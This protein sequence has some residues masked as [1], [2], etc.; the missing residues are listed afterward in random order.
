[1][2]DNNYNIHIDGLRLSPLS[3]IYQSIRQLPGL[4]LTF[5]FAISRGSGENWFYIILALIYGLFIFPTTLLNFY[6]FKYLFTEDELIIHSGILSKK[7]RNIPL[8]RIQNVNI[9]Q[10]FIQRIFKISK[11]QME[12]AGDANAEG[13]LD[14][15]KTSK[16][17]EIK[18]LIKD[19]QSNIEKKIDKKVEIS[20]E[21]NKNLNNNEYK[22]EENI[23]STIPI[24][25]DEDKELISM[26]LKQ[27]IIYGILRFRP[28]LFVLVAWIYS[29]GKQFMPDDIQQYLED[30]IYN[31]EEY[32]NSMN[33]FLV[34][35][36]FIGLFIVAF[37]LSWIMDILLTINQWWNF[38]L[39]LGKN[40]LYT[41]H[42]LL[43]KRHGTIPL[44]KLQMIVLFSNVIRQKFGYWGLMLETAGLSSVEN[45]R[46][47]TA[48]PFAKFDNVIKLAKGILNFDFPIEYELVSR[49]T[50]RR[51]FIRYFLALLIITGVAYSFG[52]DYYWFALLLPLIYFGAV[53]RWQHRGWNIQNDK[54]II[55]EGFYSRRIK[56]IP[57][58]KI[59]TIN[60][61]RSFFQRRLQLATLHI[62]TAAS[63]G[64][65]DASIIDIDENDALKLME[66]ISKRFHILN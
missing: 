61:K 50:I 22:S 6:Y 17:N 44:K 13:V 60:V 47:E 62:D 7:Q 4:A 58:D 52:L 37:V 15:I 49:K 48:V 53:L 59:Q 32:S 41:S 29:I 30:A 16:A 1:M 23:E 10:N 31:I 20:S 28:I 46:P 45:R 63:S 26:S 9:T 65:N 66:V 36:Y 35:L 39:T 56:I 64:I 25:T 43:N 24:D 5:Y 40:K 55:K 3:I 12:T 42:G 8:K 18:A 57:I 51:A 34:S 19:Y 54:I 14:S 38:K 2:S 27:L 21:S 33:W 11:I